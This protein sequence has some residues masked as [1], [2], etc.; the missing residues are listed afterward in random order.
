MRTSA[1]NGLAVA[2]SVAALGSLS[3][4]PA[5]CGFPVHWLASTLIRTWV[6]RGRVDLE[7]AQVQLGRE[8]AERAPG[9]ALSGLR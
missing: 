4:S 2:Q 7:G 6:A 8:R 1:A 3:C 9:K 5:Y